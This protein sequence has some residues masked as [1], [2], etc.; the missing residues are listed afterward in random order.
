MKTKDILLLAAGLGVGYLLL[1]RKAEVP[2][3]P[4]GPAIG[5]T[6][7]EI[8]IALP[9]TEAAPTQAPFDIGGLLSGLGGIMPKGLGISDVLAIIEA[10]DITQPPFPEDT[11][12][13]DIPDWF[14]Q[15]PGWLTQGAPGW[16]NMLFGGNGAGNGEPDVSETD[17]LEGIFNPFSGRFNPFGIFPNTTPIAT[18]AKAGGETM[19]ADVSGYIEDFS[20][21]M[22]GFYEALRGKPWQEIFHPE[23]TPPSPRSEALLRTRL[24][25]QQFLTM[26]PSEREEWFSEFRPYGFAFAPPAPGM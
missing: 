6:M 8:A 10:R 7:P 16:W 23:V 3:M 24:N 18:S 12:E 9:S 22:H 25:V 1:S 13:T 21:G 20:R 14:E 2:F 11:S 15:G 19:V 4:G 5:I 26:S 17:P